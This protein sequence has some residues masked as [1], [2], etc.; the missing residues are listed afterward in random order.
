MRTE[1][2]RAELQPRNI[3]FGRRD[4]DYQAALDEIIIYNQWACEFNYVNEMKNR[5]LTKLMPEV[6]K[7]RQKPNWSALFHKYDSNRDGLMT[8]QDLMKM[9]TDCKMEHVTSAEVGFVFS[10]IAKHK[11]NL[12]LATFIDWGE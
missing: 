5:C 3:K 12:N 10:V 6:F 4:D 2:S 9:M 1:Y 7:R 8:K 11:K